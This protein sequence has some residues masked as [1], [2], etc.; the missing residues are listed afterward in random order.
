MIFPDCLGNLEMKSPDCL[1]NLEI[2]PDCLGNLQIAWAI[3]D[4]IPG[5]PRQFGDEIYTCLG[6]LEIV[7]DC[8]GNLQICRLPRQFVNS[9]IA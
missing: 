5:L 6:T 2:F 4:D 9:Q 8:L 3:V 7:P 1:G